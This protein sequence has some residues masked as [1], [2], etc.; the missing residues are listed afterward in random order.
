LL[1]ATI[2]LQRVHNKEGNH[3]SDINNPGGCSLIEDQQ[4]QNLLPGPTA[5]DSH[6]KIGRNVRIVEVG[7]ELVGFAIRALDQLT[8]TAWVPS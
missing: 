4:V 6:V 1:K 7:I 2:N 8:S 5:Q 3:G